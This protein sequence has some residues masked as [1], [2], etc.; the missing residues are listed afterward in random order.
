MFKMDKEYSEFFFLKND[1][2]LMCDT[3]VGYLNSMHHTEFL[4]WFLSFPEIN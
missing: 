4:Y 1:V 2:T 3:I